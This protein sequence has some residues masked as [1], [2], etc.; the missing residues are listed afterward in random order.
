MGTTTEETSSEVPGQDASTLGIYGSVSTL[1]IVNHIKEFLVA[2]AEAS[3]I[4]LGPENIRIMGLEENGHRLKTLGR[5]EVEISVG[6]SD[7]EPVRKMVE[8]LPPLS[9]HEGP[10]DV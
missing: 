8:I 5:W 10:S 1:D 9:E 4:A 2:D 7:T 3:L 6:T